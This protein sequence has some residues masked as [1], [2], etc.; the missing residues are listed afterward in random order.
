MRRITLKQAREKAG[1]TQDALAD[2]SGVPQA[3]ISKIETGKLTNPR[4]DDVVSLAVALKV[5][6][7]RLKFGIHH[8]EAVA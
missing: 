7:V 6:P 1:L 4:W 5:E 3:T 8:S 2:K